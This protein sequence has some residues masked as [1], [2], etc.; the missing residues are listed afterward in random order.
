MLDCKAVVPGTNLSP[1]I[2]VCATYIANVVSGVLNA[3]G[4]M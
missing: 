2:A 4:G 3:L 1:G